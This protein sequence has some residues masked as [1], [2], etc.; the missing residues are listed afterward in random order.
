MN[1]CR[2]KLNE[3]DDAEDEPK[4]SRHY[5]YTKHFPLNHEDPSSQHDC[6]QR[7]ILLFGVGKERD[8]KKHT[9]KK[10]AKGWELFKYWFS[11]YFSHSLINFSSNFVRSAN[12]NQQTLFE[13]IQHGH[14]R[15]WQSE[16]EFSCRLQF[17]YNH[18]QIPGNDLF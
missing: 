3:T 18:N 10:M 13:E 15:R 5:I 2:T 14:G 6:N 12:R 4:L 16:K 17:R 1:I 7:Y 9:V 11:H 8:E